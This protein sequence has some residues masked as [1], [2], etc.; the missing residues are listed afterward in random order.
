MPGSASNTNKIEAGRPL[1]EDFVETLSARS[2]I[3]CAFSK[4]ECEINSCGRVAEAI[5]CEV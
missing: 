2:A 5:M 4:L 3:H 1:R